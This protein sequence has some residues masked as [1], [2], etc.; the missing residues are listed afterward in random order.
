MKRF[1]ASI[2]IDA[3]AEAVWRVLAD[4]SQWAGWDPNANRSEG[5]A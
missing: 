1:A 4:I 5:V 2:G 3:P